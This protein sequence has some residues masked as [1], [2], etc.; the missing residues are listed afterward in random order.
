VLE[1]PAS[2]SSNRGRAGLFVPQTFVSSGG[3]GVY[4][5]S[6]T[7]TTAGAAVELEVVPVVTGDKGAT[8]AGGTTYS[9]ALGQGLMTNGISGSLTITDQTIRR[10]TLMTSSGLL[11]GNSSAA[12]YLAADDVVFMLGSDPTNMEPQIVVFSE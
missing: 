12:L 3:G 9:S 2:D 1:R 8:F 10:G 7:S 4:I 5:G 11:A 6:S